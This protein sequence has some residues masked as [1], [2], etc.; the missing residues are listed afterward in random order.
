MK[1]VSERRFLHFIEEIK[2]LFAAKDDIPTK[3]SQLE[4]RDYNLLENRPILPI[5]DLFDG[6]LFTYEDGKPNAQGIIP[7]RNYTFC[8]NLD[9][10]LNDKLF[11]VSKPDNITNITLFIKAKKTDGTITT[12]A[13]IMGIG[14]GELIAIDTD[15]INKSA[16][17]CRV[18]TGQFATIIF[19]DDGS[20]KSAGITTPVPSSDVLTKTNM[21]PYSP[22]SNYHPATK[23]YVDDAIAALKEELAGGTT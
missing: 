3:F 11:R 19:N 20:R 14:P 7:Y 15:K 6:D 1:W 23:K 13:V 2:K 12:C 9:L 22:T 10:D 8:I 21:S 16:I 17:I 4:S 18:L 5:D